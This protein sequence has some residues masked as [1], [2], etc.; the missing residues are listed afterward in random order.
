MAAKQ[1]ANIKPL[2]GGW[3]QLPSGEKTRGKAVALALVEEQQKSKHMAVAE[4]MVA[5][6]DLVSRLRFLQQAG[7][8]YKANRDIYETAGYIAE[9][10]ETFDNYW[11]RYERDPVAGRIVD[12]PPKTTWKTPPE[13]FEG[14]QEK[15]DE[16]EFERAWSALAKRLKVWRGFE[17]VDRLARVGRYAVLLIGYRGGT[18]EDLSKQPEQLQG[19]RDVLYVQGYSEKYATITAWEQDPM[20]ER[21]GLPREYSIELSSGI[22]EFQAKKV[23]VHW[24]RIIHVAEDAL[25]DNVYGRPALKRALNA[26]DDLLKV[27]AS[28]GEAYWQLAAR[29]LTGEVDPGADLPPGM[30]TEMGEAL[31]EMVHDLRRHFIGQGVKL[32]WLKGETP[33]PSDAL[34][35][36]K[37]MMAVASGIPTRILFGSE[38]GQLASEQDERTYFGTINER[39]EHHAEPNILRAFIDQLLQLGALP[40]V[41]NAEEGY[42]IVWAPLFEMSE[43]DEADANLKRAEAAK[44]LTPMGGDPMDLVEVDKDRKV[45]LLTTEEAEKKRKEREDA[46]MQQVEEEEREIDVAAPPDADIGGV[47]EEEELEE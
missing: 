14:E 30:M 6:S 37:Q 34:E 27:T 31:E 36:Y 26:L 28:T 3:Y 1:E 22:S 29:I 13:V 43:E 39:Q 11:G 8:Q 5:M 9:G 35:V 42:N 25:M 24:S 33:K 10:Q 44:A 38:M 20:N 7:L 4:R 21:F 47:E 15:E 12:M 41:R 17:S 2:G 18:D 46:E 32:D 45:W 19:P 23:R 16:T 40:K